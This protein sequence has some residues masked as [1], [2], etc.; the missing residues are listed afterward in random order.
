MQGMNFSGCSVIESDF[1]SCDLTGSSF[2]GADCSGSRF[3]G[4]VLHKVTWRGAN[5]SRTVWRSTDDVR[6][7]EASAATPAK[8]AECS[9]SAELDAPPKHP[10]LVSGTDVSG[11]NLDG[12]DFGG[13]SIT[14]FNFCGV[15]LQRC[16]FLRTKLTL[17]VL[18]HSNV[19]GCDF[20]GARYRA[21]RTCQ[22]VPPRHVFAA[23][24]CA[25]LT[26]PCSKAAKG[27]LVICCHCATTTAR[28]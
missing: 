21:R 25:A 23:V 1:D 3:V 17:C 8:I 11:C 12:C 2:E 9:S 10:L 28:G 20:S 7:L 22:A 24:D 15:P 14:E 19:I 26:T 27:S 13:C 6:R 4:A 16:S 5:L 18:S